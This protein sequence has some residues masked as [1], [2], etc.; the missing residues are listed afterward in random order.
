MG[1]LFNGGG[2]LPTVQPFIDGVQPYQDVVFFLLEPGI[3]EPW[4]NG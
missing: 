2:I 3:R 4:F 1:G